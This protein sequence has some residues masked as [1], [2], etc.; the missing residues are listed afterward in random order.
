[1]TA[2]CGKDE[3]FWYNSFMMHLLA[4]ERFL[5]F[6]LLPFTYFPFRAQWSEV[7]DGGS[8]EGS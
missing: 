6:F 4:S 1:M 3:L 7:D 5:C 8:V 2:A